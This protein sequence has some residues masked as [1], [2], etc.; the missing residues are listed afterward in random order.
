MRHGTSGR[1]QR[2]NNR[3]SRNNGGGNQQR[4]RVFDSNGPDVRIRGTSH[5]IL[6]K[7]MALAKDA[8][9]SDNSV[10]AASYLQHAEHYQ[11]LI[12]GWDADVQKVAA[13]Q[14]IDD[15]EQERASR[16]SDAAQRET[17]RKESDGNTAH[18]PSGEKKEDLGLPSS[19]VGQAS[20]DTAEEA[21]SS[22]L[23]S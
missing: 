10:I 7:Y 21:R 19:L 3:G 20:A 5:Q 2:N 12:N 8:Q 13:G 1:R 14:N 9:L 11:R 23:A 16:K 17:A 22:E 4:N 6:E 18:R 15:I